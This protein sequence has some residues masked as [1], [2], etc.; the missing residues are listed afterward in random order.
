MSPDSSVY[1]SG[2]MRPFT[3]APTQR[4]PTSVCTA[5]AKSSGVAPEAS[6]F[7]SPFGVKTYTSSSKRPVRSASMNTCGSASS[8]PSTTSC[9]QRC[10]DGGLPSL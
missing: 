2:T 9:S 4:W 1:E 5:Y 3:F 6:A 7:S 8:A 10:G